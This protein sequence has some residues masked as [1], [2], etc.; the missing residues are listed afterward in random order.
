[1]ERYDEKDYS[2]G[3]SQEENMYT[4]LKSKY[5]EDLV[6][7]PRYCKYDFINN[8]YY[9]ELKSRRCLKNTYPTTMIHV[10]KLQN[11]KHKKLI[12]CFRF[13]DKDCYYEYNQND[14]LVI[15]GGGRADRGM[16]E[17][18]QYCYIPIELLTDF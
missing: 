4:K 12:L 17:Y 2:Y 16:H 7:M 3:L 5:G 8:N 11:L 14:N 18:G 9:I 6:K 15:T 13:I 1:M 10:N